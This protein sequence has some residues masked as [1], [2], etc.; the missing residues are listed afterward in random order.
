MPSIAHGEALRV[1][2]GHMSGRVHVGT[3]YLAEP[4]A[5]NFF[6]FDV[7]Y[8]IN[9]HGLAAHM[10]GERELG[11]RPRLWHVQVEQAIG[12][13]RERVWNS[14]T[15]RTRQ[16]ARGG[17]RGLQQ[18]AVWGAGAILASVLLLLLL[19][20]RWGRALPSDGG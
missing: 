5:A 18:R 15:R 2:V 6:R 11:H 14:T 13:S 1:A 9:Q 17:Q 7:F 3:W 16:V 12:Q 19:L 8:Y 20:P 4:P 10:R